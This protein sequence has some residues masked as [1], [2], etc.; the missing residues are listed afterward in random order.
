MR[1]RRWGAALT[2]VLVGAALTAC[3]DGSDAAKSRAVVIVGATRDARTARFRTVVQSTTTGET[4]RMPEERIDGL[5]DF[6]HDGGRI[7]PQPSGSG[8]SLDPS[9][10]EV[11]WIGPVTYSATNDELSM[12]RGRRWTALDSE[13]QAARLGCPR[14]TALSAATAF[15]LAALGG[16]PEQVLDT[17]R[18]E[19]LSLHSAGRAK[20]RGVAT[21]HWRVDL[22]QDDHVARCTRV[23]KPTR[24]ASRTLSRSLDLWTDHHDRA[25]R[26]RQS[27]TSEFTFAVGGK[28]RRY[29]STY[30]I[31]TEFYDFGVPVEVV[32]PPADD[33]FDETDLMVAMMIGPGD[34]RGDWRTVA[35]GTVAGEPWTVWFATTANDWRCYDSDHQ[36]DAGSAVSVKAYSSEVGPVAVPMHDGRVASCS[37]PGGSFGPP[38]GAYVAGVDGDRYVLAGFA[39][40][41]V[42]TITLELEDG[43]TVRVPVDPATGM[44]EWTGAPKPAPVKVTVDRE[45]CG[46]QPQFSIGSAP[47]PE[48]D[49]FSCRPSNS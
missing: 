45:S 16:K 21:T 38:F 44:V 14:S 6:A 39:D 13:Q 35:E 29:R 34:V 2:V 12:G 24:T 43:A 47:L 26:V 31:T 27:N 19:G 37:P 41:D 25:R 30:T 1:V 17:L 9:T 11:R 15:G 8:N 33:V 4:S 7:V 40:R 46:L 20:V 28:T 32:A 36:P 49:L 10:V 18:A 42:D 22:P 5:V 3:G 23:P 48:V